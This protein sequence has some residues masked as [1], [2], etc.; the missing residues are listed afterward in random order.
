MATVTW[1]LADIVKEIPI[2]AKVFQRHRLDFCCGGRQSLAQ[3]CAATGADPAAVMREIESAAQAA[4]EAQDRDSIRWTDR[5]IPELVQHILDRYHATLRTE[6]PRLIELSR[7]V[8]ERHADKPDRPAGLAD[9]LTD[10]QAAVDS[11]LEKE[12][13]ILFPM[14]IAGHGQMAYMPIQV[15]MMEHE[16]HGRNLRRIRE[17][18]R[19][20][21]VPEHACASWRELYRAL[22]EFEADLMY[23]IHLENNIL[24]PRVLGS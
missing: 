6:I 11:H 10:V 12:E 21:A 4:S 23:H 16:D 18:T 7:K 24:F 13:Q 8:E 22:A 1:T 2:A 17:I 15:M 5:P 19:D 20:L 9:L 3:A 14:I